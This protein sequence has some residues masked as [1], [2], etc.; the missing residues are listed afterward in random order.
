MIN[1]KMG[2]C[3]FYKLEALRRN[4]SGQE[5]SRRILADWF[6]NLITDSGM[7]YLGGGS[8]GANNYLSQCR[9][10]SGNTPPVNSD[11]TLEVPVAV[12]ATIISNT[13]TVQATAPYFGVNTRTYQFSAGAAAGNLSEIGIGPPVIDTNLFSRALIVDG[14]GNP[15]TITILPDEILQA[16]YQLRQYPSLV[17]VPGSVTLDGNLYNL[18]IRAAFV[19]NFANAGLQLVSLQAGRDSFTGGLNSNVY[20]TQTLGAIEAGPAGTAFGTTTSTNAAYVA[21]T[22]Q[23][24]STYSYSISQGNPPGGVGAMTVAHTR[25]AYQISFTPVVPKTSSET[26]SMTYRWSWVRHVFP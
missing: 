17:D 21:G 10:G 23:R 26:F 6:P 5:I 22:F 2:I 19:N 14:G 4:S 12:T 24:D 8:S 1:I 11:T 7:D 25:G 18:V 20:A 3:G 13:E 9:V 15:I 16:T